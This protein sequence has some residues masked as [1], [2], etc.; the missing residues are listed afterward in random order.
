MEQVAARDDWSSWHDWYADRASVAFKAFTDAL[1]A[2][3]VIRV[4]A[5][6]A[7]NTW[8]A[9]MI[10]QKLGKGNFDAMACTCYV[11]GGTSNYDE[12]TTASDIGDALITSIAEKTL[13]LWRENKDLAD[14]FGVP[15]LAY[16]GGQHVDPSGNKNVSWYEAYEAVQTHPK[17]GEAYKSLMESWY[18]ELGGNLLCFYSSHGYT[19]AWGAWGA[20][21]RYQQDDA[22]KY[23]AIVS[24]P[25]A[26]GN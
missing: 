15:L 1:G 7:A 2:E 23:D 24:S 22:V 14:E 25:Y 26:K 10:A 18:E 19:N 21:E 20:I 9:S 13:G 4:V 5:G 6:Q 11:S 8:H 17:M 16:E 3:R 12:S